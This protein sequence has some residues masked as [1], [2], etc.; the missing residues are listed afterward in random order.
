MFARALTIFGANPIHYGHIDLIRKSLKSVEQLEIYIG[1][2][3]RPSRLPHEVRV[4]SLQRVLAHEEFTSRVTLIDPK[5]GLR[6]LR[7]THNILAVGSRFLN[8]YLLFKPF[9]LELIRLLSSIIVLQIPGAPLTHEARLWSSS[10]AS[11]IEYDAATHFSSTEL[12]AMY[13]AGKSIADAVPFAALEVIQ[14]H[15]QSYFNR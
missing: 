3:P 8:N 15:M 1:R 12:R 2:K 7:G 11:L 14:D 5:G 4:E 10:F 13:C 6:S 9:E